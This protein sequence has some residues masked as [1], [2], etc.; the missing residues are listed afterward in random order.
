MFR[1]SKT[2]VRG[3]YSTNISISPHRRPSNKFTKKAVP[4]LIPI[5][6]TSSRI[7]L[8]VPPPVCL[9]NFPSSVNTFWC[10]VRMRFARVIMSSSW[11][12]L[13]VVAGAGAAVVGIV[14]PAGL[15]SFR[16]HLIKGGFRYHLINSITMSYLVFALQSPMWTKV[17]FFEVVTPFSRAASYLRVTAPSCSHF[18]ALNR[19]SPERV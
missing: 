18:M 19:I 9:S 16:Y 2:H 6:F 8:P 5:I 14:L 1:R 12:K 13:R 3:F 10:R 11:S 7:W 4:K 15:K 17:G